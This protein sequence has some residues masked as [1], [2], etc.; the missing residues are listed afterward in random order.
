[1]QEEAGQQKDDALGRDAERDA[2]LPWSITCT[3][4]L[5]APCADREH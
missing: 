4:T 5:G 1:M 2:G 3:G